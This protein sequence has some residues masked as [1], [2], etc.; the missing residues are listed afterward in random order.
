MIMRLRRY[1]K[2]KIYHG[3][4]STSLAPYHMRGRLLI[5]SDNACTALPLIWGGD[6]FVIV[7]AW[8][9]MV[10]KGKIHPFM[11]FTRIA[12]KKEVRWKQC[13]SVHLPQD[14]TRTEEETTHTHCYLQQRQEIKRLQGPVTHRETKVKTSFAQLPFVSVGIRRTTQIQQSPC[15]T[16]TQKKRLR[17]GRAFISMTRSRAS[18][19]SAMPKAS[20]STPHFRPIIGISLTARLQGDA[21]RVATAAGGNAAST[22]V[23]QSPPLSG[24]PCAR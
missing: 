18:P 17:P 23:R 15:G 20:R 13:S 2:T 1:L 5:Q 3:Y 22:A 10:S 9:T 24:C 12:L 7:R 16:K 11:D 14:R 21:W 19:V 4:R 8:P 6:T